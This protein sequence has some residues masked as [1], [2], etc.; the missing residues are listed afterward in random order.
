MRRWVAAG[1]IAL[2]A[3]ATAAASAGASAG[4]SSPAD[5][6]L[7][8]Q[9]HVSGYF[10][11][12]AAISSDDAWAAGNLLHGQAVVYRPFVRHW[13]GLSWSAVTI[14]G[15]VCGSARSCTGRAMRG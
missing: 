4:A 14:P 11:S 13:D 6:N 9:A 10:L 8:Y 1:A 3:L 7:F 15:A 2:A 5:W 12:V